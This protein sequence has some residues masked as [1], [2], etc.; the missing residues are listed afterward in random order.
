MLASK[1][2]TFIPGT[3]AVSIGEPIAPVPGESSA[4]LMDKVSEWIE[5][6]MRRIDP[7]AYKAEPLLEDSVIQRARVDEGLG[8]ARSR[9]PGSAGQCAGRPIAF[10]PVTVLDPH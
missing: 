6:E 9:R 5:A 3:I 2:F 1:S 4:D 8:G 10:V 7:D